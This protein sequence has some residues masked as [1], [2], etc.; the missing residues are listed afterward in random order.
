M[1]YK[2]YTILDGDGHVIESL[3]GINKLM[4][5]VYHA[6]FK[7]GHPFYKPFGQLDH[8]H[9]T[10][11]LDFMPGSFNFLTGPKEWQEFAGKVGVDASVLY[12]T[13]GLAIGKIT[14]VQFS[15]DA[16][17]A[18]N[19]WLYQTY[20]KQSPVFKGV[21]LL[22]MDDVEAAVIELRR[23]VKELG[24]CG[25]MIASTGFQSHI[26]HKRY[27]PIYEEADRLGCAMAVHGGAHENFGMDD[28]SPFAAVHALG[29]PFG[30]MICFA[31][32]IFHGLCD[33]FPRVKWAFLEGG[34]AWLLMCLERFEGSYAGFTP[35]DTGKR[36]FDIKK[37]EKVFDYIARHVDAGRL[38][39]GCEGDEPN[40]ADAV[41]DIGDK[42][43]IFSSDFPHEVNI[44]SCQ[45]EIDE[46]LENE[47]LTKANKEAILS[48]NA[49]RLYGI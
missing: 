1:A 34:V 36:F 15:V 47:K 17:R 28:L 4:P 45:H 2:G 14:D 25:A 12:P 10:S 29:H 46:L 13:W 20:M 11:L 22:P 44:E 23:A 40:L 32:V 41:R 18:Y 5:E 37:G 48:G 42:P 6:P 27:W 24:M 21:C 8:M 43:F 33:R 7:A 30:Q 31:S 38:F 49:R 3:E 16:C 26:G 35:R 19:D 39:V 9:Q